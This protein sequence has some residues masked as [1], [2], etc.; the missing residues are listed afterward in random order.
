M[1][2]GPEF[3]VLSNG[4]EWPAVSIPDSI[5]I[6]FRCGRT[7]H[8]FHASL[9]SI[10][11]I[12]SQLEQEGEV[13]EHVGTGDRLVVDP[14]P[15]DSPV[16]DLAKIRVSPVTYF[17]GFEEITAALEELLGQAFECVDDVTKGPPESVESRRKE[18][19]E[20]I[21]QYLE[22]KNLEPVAIDYYSRYGDEEAEGTEL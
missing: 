3:E 8:R 10:V 11:S 19:L 20:V 13:D 6:E 21:N 12:M 1:V 22:T 9:E 18:G 15:E 14:D 2:Q 17:A 16:D 7:T 4:A 5:D